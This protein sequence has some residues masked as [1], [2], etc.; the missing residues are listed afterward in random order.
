LPGIGGV[1]GGRSPVQRTLDAANTGIT[2]SSGVGP[3]I[4]R[5]DTMEAAFRYSSVVP[6]ASVKLSVIFA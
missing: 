2:L 5:L 6:S 4:L 1:K 3:R